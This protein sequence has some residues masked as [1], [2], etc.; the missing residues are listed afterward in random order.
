MARALSVDYS[1][2]QPPSFIYATPAQH[3][4]ILGGRIRDGIEL[5]TSNILLPST[6][7]GVLQSV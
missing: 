6:I 5:R 2:Q 1:A 7:H 4:S 3:Q